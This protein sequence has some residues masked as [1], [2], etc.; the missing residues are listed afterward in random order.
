MD[1]EDFK[2]KL[3]ENIF[4]ATTSEELSVERIFEIADDI[5]DK[6]IEAAKEHINNDYE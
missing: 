6:V 4:C 3:A 5:A 1:I 2:R